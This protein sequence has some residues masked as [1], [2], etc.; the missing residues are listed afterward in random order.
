MEKTTLTC[1]KCGHKQE[2]QIP[3]NACIPFYKCDSC[4]EMISPK[5]GDCCVFCS[6]G[7]KACPV[8]HKKN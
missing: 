5:D 2:G 7:D 3:T 6:Y 8:G 1:P 4:G